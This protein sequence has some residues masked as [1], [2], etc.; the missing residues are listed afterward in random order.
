MMN[1]NIIDHNYCDFGPHAGQYHVVMS[2]YVTAAELEE[3]QQRDHPIGTA[4]L[5]ETPVDLN[6]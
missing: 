5:G 6:Q 4:E 2:G 3:L 1:L